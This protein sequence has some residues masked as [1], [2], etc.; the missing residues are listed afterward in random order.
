MAQPAFHTIITDQPSFGSQISEA[1]GLSD[2]G[3]VAVGSSLMQA[4]EPLSPIRAVMAARYDVEGTII[5]A[6]AYPEPRFSEDN[7]ARTV[8]LALV[9][10][11]VY[12][13]VAEE[14]TPG[15]RINLLLRR[16]DPDTGEELYRLP[17]GPGDP[18]SVFG[19][20]KDFAVVDDAA[21]VVRESRG[22]FRPDADHA[23]QVFGLDD[24]LL[25][26]EIVKPA[27]YDDEATAWPAAGL[28]VV[29]NAPRQLAVAATGDTTSL[30]LGDVPHPESDVLMF[31]A[32]GKRAVYVAG[33]QRDTAAFVLATAYGGNVTTTI[34]SLPPELDAR[35]VLDLTAWGPDS[36]AVTVYGTRARYIADVHVF[37]MDGNYGRLLP[38]VADVVHH[39][40]DGPKHGF[41]REQPAAP[42]QRRLLYR[43]FFS[44]DPLGVV[45][46]VS[47]DTL[48]LP[49]RIA[50]PDP[51][52][53]DN[54]TAV[55]F[56]TA[57]ELLG[58]KVTGEATGDWF[59]FDDRGVEIPLS[60]RKSLA[61]L[62]FFSPRLT[63]FGNGRGYAV[64]NYGEWDF[65]TRGAVVDER[66][67]QR[68]L[69]QLAPGRASIVGA[70]P[71]PDGG[72]VYAL[73]QTDT[74]LLKHVSSGGVVRDYATFP[75]NTF[76][77]GNPF[78]GGFAV[79]PRG[80]VALV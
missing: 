44:S 77:G 74:L 22:G 8:Q 36:F 21:V 1:A 24:G 56:T 41:L 57:G 9:G 59:K 45:D 10:D 63:T 5:W 79:G 2:G 51:A 27:G 69:L 19:L 34:R 6:R 53:L 18:L 33:G 71:H 62:Q 46:Y 23:V 28:V 75:P 54:L 17:L 12:L 25:R 14:P 49:P 30:A 76:G 55:T 50:S 35:L 39:Y 3:F 15:S 26:A 43:S 66:L 29:D 52:L 32:N 31:L 78:V 67:D 20:P 4:D 61:P 48:A 13:L 60:P 11:T 64:H 40:I 65:L 80:E 72:I 70:A 37:S 47:G 68:D 42:K 73:K 38:G 58:I 7:S 16:I